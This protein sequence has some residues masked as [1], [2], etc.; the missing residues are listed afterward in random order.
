MTVHSE[1]AQRDKNQAALTSVVAAI[2]LTTFKII[3]SLSCPDV[4]TRCTVSQAVL[5]GIRSLPWFGK[6]P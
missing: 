4:S 3:V 5:F 6:S 2:G 1:E